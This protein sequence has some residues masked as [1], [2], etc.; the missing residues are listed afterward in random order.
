MK[1]WMV[2]V[3]GAVATQFAAFAVDMPKVGDIAPDFS[4]AASDGT[5]VHLKDY[6]GKGNIILYFYPKDDTKGCT[7]EACS[8]RDT[9]DEF[10]GLNATILGVSFDSVA[11][12]KAF[13][14]KYN[15]PFVLLADTDKS[16][17]KLYGAAN[18]DSKHASRV[19]F[20][21][22]KAGRIAFVDP[23]VNPAT[24]AAELQAVLKSLPQ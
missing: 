23:K 21:I 19:T 17:A 9:F 6:I 22:S 24:H 3:V 11:S 18:D 8:I 20:V 13:I 2:M 10:K 4:V 12:H 1:T 16:V 7:I 14:A 15:L 5:T